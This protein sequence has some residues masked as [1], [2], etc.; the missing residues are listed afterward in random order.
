MSSDLED[1]LKVTRSEFTMANK[2]KS[3]AS[4]QMLQS[5]IELWL[6][7]LLLSIQDLVLQNWYRLYLFSYGDY[8]NT[9]M[10]VE[11]SIF[12]NIFKVTSNESKFF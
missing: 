6:K 10:Q 5:R 3:A 2:A 11:K 4:L 1:H 7:V 12:R 8:G 9:W